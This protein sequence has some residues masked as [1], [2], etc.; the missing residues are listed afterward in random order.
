MDTNV[1]QQFVVVRYGGNMY[2]VRKAPFE[3]EYVA[4][5]RAWYI[6]TKLSKDA[7]ITSWEERD[8]LS[9]IW[10]NKRYFDMKYLNEIPE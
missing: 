2:K 10:C 8:S 6:A 5:D 7:S 3:T 4:Y 9:H 1:V